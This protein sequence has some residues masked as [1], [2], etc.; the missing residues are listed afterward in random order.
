MSLMDFLRASRPPAGVTAAASRIPFHAALT[1]AFH[2]AALAV[3]IFSEY[4]LVEKFVF[5]LTW[6][7]L[8]FFFLFLTRRPAT[9]GAIS[10]TLILILIILSRLKHEVIW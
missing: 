5:L 9:A 8:N 6:A 1:F 4:G 3:M 2:L 10:L 7:L